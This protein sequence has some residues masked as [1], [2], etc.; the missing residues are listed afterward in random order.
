[1]AYIVKILPR[2]EKDLARIYLYINAAMSD[3]AYA[4]YVG[5]VEQLFTLNVS[6]LRNSVTPEDP[7]YR[8]LLYGQK[9][10]VYRVIYRV[11]DRTKLV[12]ILMIRHG[13]RD[14]FK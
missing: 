1:M 3:A 14:R 4:W 11:I 10:D 2:A 12:E 8:H 13:A 5:L 9:S 7:K 6:P